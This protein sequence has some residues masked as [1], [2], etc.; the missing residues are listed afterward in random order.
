MADAN[1]AKWSVQNG[2]LDKVKQ[3]VSQAG[4]DINADVGMG[5][6]LIHCAADY[7][8]TEVLE[9]LIAN[10]ANVNAKDKHGITPLLNAIFEGHTA[11]VKLLLSKGADK[12]VKAPSGESA[13]ESAE[14]DE[15][16]DLLR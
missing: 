5:R 13:L 9:F 4:F 11:S 2:D 10:G 12:T 7:G 16:K 6:A 8:Q 14:K 3:A 15:I 1:E